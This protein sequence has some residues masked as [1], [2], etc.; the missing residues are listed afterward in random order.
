V[1]WVSEINPRPD[2]LNQAL[3]D[4]EA[5]HEAAGFEAQDRGGMPRYIKQAGFSI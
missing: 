4:G 1:V 2:I 3:L 5:A